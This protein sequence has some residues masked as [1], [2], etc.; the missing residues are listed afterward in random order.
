MWLWE[1]SLLPEDFTWGQHL[2]KITKHWDVEAWCS[3]A[4][5]GEHNS[6]AQV[7]GSERAV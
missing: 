5:H 2:V 4:K 1:K 7:L 6:A 3:E